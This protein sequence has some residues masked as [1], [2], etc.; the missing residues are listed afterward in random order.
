MKRTCTWCRTSL[1][2]SAFPRN[3]RKGLR[4]QRK[5]CRRQRRS[6]LACGAQRKSQFAGIGSY[7]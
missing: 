1:P 4:A 2:L 7:A 3:G 5:L 6:E